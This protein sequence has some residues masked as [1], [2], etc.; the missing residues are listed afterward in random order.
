MLIATF[1]PH[2]FYEKFFK[3]LFQFQM[4]LSSQ[5]VLHMFKANKKIH[6]YLDK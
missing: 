2:P 3:I 6:K 4:Y 5:K 1:N